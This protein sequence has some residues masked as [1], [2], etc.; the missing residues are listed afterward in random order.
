MRFWDHLEADLSSRLDIMLNYDIN[1]TVDIPDSISIDL[2]NLMHKRLASIGSLC[3]ELCRNGLKLVDF[4]HLDVDLKACGSANSVPR[5]I[6]DTG[7]I[8]CHLVIK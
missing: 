7:A 5:K 1:F 3:A 8:S 2:G 4:G 6:M